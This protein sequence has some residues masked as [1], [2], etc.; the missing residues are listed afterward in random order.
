ML[1]LLLVVEKDSKREQ[2][3]ISTLKNI[4]TTILSL[5]VIGPSTGTFVSTKPAIIPVLRRYPFQSSLSSLFVTSKNIIHRR[6]Y[7]S[8]NMVTTSQ[9]TAAVKAVGSSASVGIYWYR[10]A[11]RFHDNPSLLDAC[12]NCTTLLPVYIIDPEYPFHQSTGIKAGCIR[13]N[14]ALESMKEVHTKLETQFQSRLIVIVGKATTV[15]PQII[16]AFNVTDLYYEREPA[17]PIRESDRCVLEAIRKEALPKTVAIH[18]YD[19]HTLHPMESYLSKCK[20]HVAPSTYGGFTKIFQSFPRLKTEVKDVTCVPPLPSNT[21]KTIQQLFGRSDSGSIPSLEE[22]GYQDVS[23]TLLNRKRGG[24]DFIGGEDFALN[25]LTQQMSRA[26]WVAT[27]EK[28]NTSPNA[29]TVDTTG[30]SPC[31]YSRS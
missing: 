12:T 15:L 9:S 2:A 26:Q 22:L 24:I 1:V 6:S 28:P 30:L 13:A 10:N 27:F 3:I 21:A 4:V 29:L 8:T 31:M 18:G 16:A 14:F 11:L 20:G 7:V 23:T 25:L 17:L 19:T 5:L